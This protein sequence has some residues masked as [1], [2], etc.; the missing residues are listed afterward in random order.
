MV[1]RTTGRMQQRRHAA[2]LL[3]I[4]SVRDVTSGSPEC[5][6]AAVGA[7]THHELLLLIPHNAVNDGQR[8]E[9]VEHRLQR[10]ALAHRNPDAASP[11]QYTRHQE[12]KHTR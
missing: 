9:A 12:R 1:R 6:V 2:K 8:L 3:E 10:A 7:A 5:S 11:G 4:V